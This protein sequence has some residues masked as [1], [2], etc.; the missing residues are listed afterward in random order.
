M[1]GHA[2]GCQD[3]D[4]VGFGPVLQLQHRVD[5]TLESYLDRHVY[6][7]GEAVD[8]GL[9]AAVFGTDDEEEGG[10][11]GS[12]PDT[13]RAQATALGNRKSARSSRITR[14]RLLR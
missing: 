8:D 7:F 6:L 4:V 13:E 2:C 1:P 3:G 5:R 9:E 10:G 11:S 12:T 14:P